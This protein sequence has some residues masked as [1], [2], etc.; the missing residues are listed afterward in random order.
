MNTHAAHFS[1]SILTKKGFSK[2][3]CIQHALVYT[4]HLRDFF[5]LS[6]I[7]ASRERRDISCSVHKTEWHSNLIINL[8]F[9]LDNGDE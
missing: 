5:Y 1:W 3:H 6:A 8:C 4:V 2:V 9:A 7:Q